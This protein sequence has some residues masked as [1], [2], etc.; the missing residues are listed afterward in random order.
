VTGQDLAQGVTNVGDAGTGNLTVANGG[1]VSLGF[2]LNLGNQSTGNGTVLVTDAGSTFIAENSSVNYIGKYGTGNLTVANGGNFTGSGFY[3]AG[4]SASTGTVLVTDADSQ[5]NV[6]GLIVGYGGYGNLAVVNGGSLTTHNLEAGFA[7]YTSTSTVLVTDANS[8]LNISNSFTAGYFSNASLTVA[9]GGSVTGEANYTLGSANAGNGTVLV[10]DTGSSLS[11][12]EMIVGSSGTGNLTVA[13]GGTVVA[14]GLNVGNDTIFVGFA[15]GS[16]GNITVTDTGSN[17]TVNNGALIVGLGGNAS[18][19]VA[20]GA[21]VNANGADVNGQSAVLGYNTS[22]I[23][24]ASV[25]GNGSI[26]NVTGGRL[27]VGSSG[28]GNLSITNGGGVQ[29]TAADSSGVSLALGDMLNS[30]GNMLVDGLG[31]FYYGQHTLTIGNGGTGNATVANGGSVNITNGSLVLGSE[32]GSSGTFNLNDGGTLSVGGTNGIASGEG[33]Y[34]FNFNGGTL[35]ADSDLTSSVNFSLGDGTT[36]TINTNGNTITFAGDLTGNTGG[37]DVNGGGTL[38]SNGNDTYTGMTSV[39]SGNL[40]INDQHASPVSVTGPSAVL[41]GNGTIN[42][43]V[44]ITAG[45][46][47]SPGI[48]N[49]VNKTPV[50][51]GTYAGTASGLAGLTINGN[52][53]WSVSNTTLV[54]HLS[55]SSLNPLASDTLNVVGALTN[56]GSTTATLTFD[57]ENTGYFDGVNNPTY[58]LITASNDLS[59]QFSLSQFAATNVWQDKASDT[60]SYFLFADG[61]TELQFVIVPEPATW[62]LLLGGVTLLM[63]MRRK[64]RKL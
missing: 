38:V 39:T 63:G 6:I 59:Q 48:N 21:T 7:D 64:R 35:V 9:N 24:T 52:L 1:S 4:S 26:W 23:A 15:T 40:V 58:T 14:S 11:A 36:S 37:L 3:L 44:T 13:N 55:S 33:D 49:T 20:N 60:K 53:S 30:M 50:T 27:V 34:S 41:G 43:D 56:T 8:T 47:V 61:G 16:T 22:S 54:W 12:N 42:N 17:L 31:S 19:S 25:D 57:F 28:S 2:T 62:G 46:A 45:G 29:V 51:G 32:S 5:M 18:L 10:T